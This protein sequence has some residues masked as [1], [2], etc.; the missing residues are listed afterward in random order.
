MSPTLWLAMSLTACCATQCLVSWW[1]MLV[2]FLKIRRRWLVGRRCRETLACTARPWKKQVPLKSRAK[3][4]SSLN[5][6]K[7]L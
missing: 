2:H 6:I 7:K 4:I 1:L 3:S 5:K